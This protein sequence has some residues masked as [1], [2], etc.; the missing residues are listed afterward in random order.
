MTPLEKRLAR[1]IHNQRVR[2]REL[3][4]FHTWRVHRWTRSPW[5]HI[6]TKVLKENRELRARLGIDGRFDQAEA[7]KDYKP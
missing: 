6:T 4:K 5:L 1:R 2:L 7:M 3:E